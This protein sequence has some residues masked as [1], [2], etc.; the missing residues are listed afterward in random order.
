MSQSLALGQL[1][2]RLS[3][4]GDGSDGGREA[5]WNGLAKSLGDT[6]NWDGYGVLQAKFHQHP[7]DVAEGLR[8]LTAS[9]TREL[10]SWATADTRRDHQPDYVL[11]STNVRLSA[12]V[13]GGKDAIKNTIRQ[14][15]QKHELRIRDFRVWDYD[16]LRTL[17]DNSEP[18]RTAYSGWIT[19]GDLVQQLLAGRMDNEK[20]FLS[21]LERHAAFSFK[22]DHYLNLRQAG[23]VSDKPTSIADTLVDLPVWNT[24]RPHFAAGVVNQPGVI[25]SLLGLGDLTP[26][27]SPEEWTETEKHRRVVLVG[28]P[29]QGKSTVTQAVAQIYRSEFLQ[30]TALAANVELSAQMSALRTRMSELDVSLP[31]A[32]RWPFRVILTHLA[33]ALSREPDLSLL[34]YI[35]AAV[36][37]RAAHEVTSGDMRVWLARHPWYLLID[38]L[39]EVPTSSN[40]E[41]VMRCISDFYI[42]V[43]AAQGDVVSAATT[44]PQGYSNEFDP[45]VHQHWTLAPLNRDQAL[46]YARALVRIRAGSENETFE[47]TMHRLEVASLDESTLRLFASPLQVTILTVLLE[48]LG[49]VPRDRWRLFSEYYRVISQRE[50]EKG[51][52]LAQLLQTY[53][54]DIDFVHREVGYLLQQRSSSAGETSA[55]LSISEFEEIIRKRLRDHDHAD[56]EV[57]ELT[58]QFMQLAT[59]RLVFLSPLSAGVIGFE[60][61]SLQEFMAGEYISALPDSMIADALRGVAESPH[62]RN[63]FLFAVGCIFATKDHHKAEIVTICSDVDTVDLEAE[64][65][66]RGSEL[67]IDILEDGA[68]SSQPKYLRQLGE[69]ASRIIDGPVSPLAKRLAG[70]GDAAVASIVRDRATSTTS[71]PL[72]VWLNRAIVLAGRV[73]N[74][75]TAAFEDLV[76]L[77]ASAP[78]E[79]QSELTAFAIESSDAD[80][81]RSVEPLLGKQDLRKILYLN[82]PMDGDWI[83]SPD[84]YPQVFA[85]L[86]SVA[87]SIDRGEESMSLPVFDGLNDLR[88]SLLP[89]GSSLPAWELLSNVDDGGSGWGLAGKVAEFAHGPS[90]Q[91]LAEVLTAA[92]DGWSGVSILAY[93]PWPIA[94]CFSNALDWSVSQDRSISVRLR[95]LSD[96]ARSGALG[97]LSDWLRWEQEW[98]QAAVAVG[99]LEQVALD[100]GGEWDMPFTSGQ[101]PASISLGTSFSYMR[102]FSESRLEMSV[103]AAERLTSVVNLSQSSHS[104]RMTEIALFL[105]GATADDFSSNMTATERLDE[106]VVRRLT[107]SYE[108]ALAQLASSSEPYWDHESIAFWTLGFAPLLLSDRD[109]S[110]PIMN[111]LRRIGRRSRIAR[112]FSA[113]FSLKLIKLVKTTE[114]WPILR[115]AVHHNP[116]ALRS[117]QLDFSLEAESRFEDAIRHLHILVNADS[118]PIMEGEL[119]SSLTAIANIRADADSVNAALLLEAWEAIGGR[120]AVAGGLRMAALSADSRPR[121]SARFYE[122]ARMHSMFEESSATGPQL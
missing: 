98:A 73:E 54:S 69:L 111:L 106:E 85:A 65:L 61:R 77:V 79:A 76:A 37:K 107:D 29:G 42:E 103:D 109:V 91:R 97:D 55:S 21:A 108:R 118:I 67:A 34:S 14:L 72:S 115:V 40:R 113:E 33:D 48:K 38:G 57:T 11:F 101:G 25:S 56:A 89:L 87:S 46:D 52:S 26:A 6:P 62:W 120:V 71:A 81:L 58:S 2:G 30:A 28:G 82:W 22:D 9:V 24:R 32:R 60:L 83:D 114:D 117:I 64:P 84:D 99:A 44:R 75:G 12:G 121:M 23:S 53:I 95:F 13:G 90:A 36:S 100:P 94:R 35:A 19:P 47:R 119:D 4:F 80:L 27:V 59:D 3:I 7:L 43:S 96:L 50:Q 105:L 112:I 16:D 63:A 41:L 70:V 31:S 17:L 18:V 122:M 39:D 74:L 5:T 8:W 86:Q 104:M 88:V 1:G 10:K 66:R 45:G 49:R 110:G 15:V 92:A 78:D 116:L 68:A 51:G 20:N 93:S 102:D